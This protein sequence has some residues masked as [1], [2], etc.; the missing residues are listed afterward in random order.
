M[1]NFFAANMKIL[2][3][4]FPE[5]AQ[6][7]TALPQPRWSLVPLNDDWYD[8]HCGESLL[9]G[10][11]PQETVRAIMEE[12]KEFTYPKMVFFYGVGL[13]YHIHEFF[14][15]D[16]AVTEHILL[17]ESSAE[18]LHH[19]LTIRDWSTILNDPR[20]TLLVEEPLSSL[21]RF[22][23]FYYSTDRL[24]Y[25]QAVSRIYDRFAL[26]QNSEFYL[27]VATAARGAELH[28]GRSLFF[29]P[30]DAYR[31][32]MNI[33]KN[34]P[35]GYGVPDVETLRNA[36]AGFP[37]IAVSTGPSL[38][39]SLGWLRDV[40]EKAVIACT[41]SALKILLE[42]GI[43]PHFTCCLE[44]VPE[45]KLLFEQLPDTVDT[46]LVTTPVIWPETYHNYPGPK[47]HMMRH[48]GQLAWFY[49]DSMAYDTGNS[50]SHVAFRLVELLGCNPICIVGQDLAF[51]RFSERTHTDGIPQLLYNV[52]QQQRQESAESAKAGKQ[53]VLVEGNDGT[54][55]LTMPW[56]SEFRKVLETFIFRCEATCYNVTPKEYGAR[57]DHAILKEPHEVLDVFTTSR[58]I[59]DE[60]RQ[61]FAGAAS[62]YSSE[63]EYYEVMQLRV[64]AA[65]DY[66]ERMCETS[67][68]TLEILSEFNQRHNPKYFG[69][70]YYG[71]LLRRIEKIIL[72]LSCDPEQFYPHFFLAQVYSEVLTLGQSS[73]TVLAQVHDPIKKISEQ[74]KLLTEWFRESHYWGARMLHFINGY[75]ALRVAREK[76]RYVAA[77]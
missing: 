3:A 6:R 35:A 65:R 19:A 77:S 50:S 40:Q 72:D 41:D 56:Y 26:M 16:T 38:K 52:G 54:P 73:H 1:N 31:G 20:V 42:N 21:P 15:G 57:I 4:R 71:P 70:D 44:R 14:A 48:I 39:H 74:L 8:L 29:S 49:P 32:Y 76:D 62:P 34:L 17:I 58:N 43:K 55:I 68:Q 7:L 25:G 24:I 59:W 45:T 30:E 28:S 2:D 75:S 37:G 64:D 53:G 5:V 27:S 22:L 33:L 13:G 66:L 18:L 23:S 11:Q 51:D 12:A 60:V 9:Y 63:S 46:Y 10:A 61:R 67:V 69:E 36:F 47:A